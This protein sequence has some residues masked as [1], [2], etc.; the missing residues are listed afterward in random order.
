MGRLENKVAVIT[1]G[2]AGIG[3]A[4]ANRFAEEGAQVFITGRRQAE[5]DKAA[6]SI[7]PRATAIQGDASTVDGIEKLYA[8][9]KEKAGRIDVLMLNAAIVTAM[10]LQKITEEHFDAMITGNLRSIVFG[11]QRALPLLGKGASVILVGSISGSLGLPALSLYCA[12]KAAVR[13]LARSWI[14]DL[15]GTGIRVNVL[16]PGHTRT[17]AFDGVVPEDRA[18]A[19]AQTLPLERLGTPEDMASLALFL[20]SDESSYITGAEIQA[21]GGAA[22]H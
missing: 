11:M 10:P 12:N 20:A 4:T 19:L 13:S 22:Q 6:A 9:V 2:S 8:K 15:K 16:S 21:D 7:G 17:A 18:T 3:L 14:V 5:L 1:G